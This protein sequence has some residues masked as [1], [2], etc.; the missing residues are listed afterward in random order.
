MKASILF[1]TACLLPCGHS[2]AMAQQESWNVL[3]GQAIVTLPAPGGDSAIIAAKLA[4]KEQKWSLML[5]PAEGAP[6]VSG[7]IS[8]AVD[9]Q[10][11]AA[12]ATPEA[13]EI[14]IPVSRK[15][16]DLFKSGIRLTVQLSL[17][18]EGTNFSLRG[19]RRAIEAAAPLCSPRDMSAYDNVAMS[20]ES[21]DVALAAKLRE[22]EIKAFRVATASEPVISAGDLR[23]EDGKRILFVQLCGSSWYFGRTNCNVA[24]FL[25]GEGPDDWRLVLDAEGAAFYA[26]PKSLTGGWPDLLAVTKT[27]PDLVWRWGG[28][29]YV[30]A[31]EAV[32]PE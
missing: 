13:G 15:V 12:Q 24:G 27:G 28:E 31:G 3:E 7:P 30:F 20:P 16:L 6:M 1:L 19:S 25:E 14:R 22:P 2:P 26:D 21:P 10:S 9:K 32:D 23:S 18:G 11:F 29:E 4:C 5:A 17:E 8:I